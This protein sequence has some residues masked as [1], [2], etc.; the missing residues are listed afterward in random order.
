MTNAELKE[1][2]ELHTK[3]IKVQIE[4][5]QEILHTEL[6]G[7]NEHLERLNGKVKKQDE[8]NDEQDDEIEHIKKDTAIVRWIRKNP[9]WAISI[10]IILIIIVPIVIDGIGFL[11]L[12]KLIK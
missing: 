1:F 10:L 2:I 5:G 3:A 4:S 8:R 12:I 11:N 7:V 9:M 6:K